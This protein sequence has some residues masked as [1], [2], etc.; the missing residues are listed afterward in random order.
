MTKFDEPITKFADYTEAN[1]LKRAVIDY[2]HRVASRQS[3][4]RLII[5][6]HFFFSNNRKETLCKINENILQGIHQ[7]FSLILKL[8]L[9]TE[10]KR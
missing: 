7:S 6:L 5:R 10:K 4:I 8:T 1:Y 2:H 9:R 3:S